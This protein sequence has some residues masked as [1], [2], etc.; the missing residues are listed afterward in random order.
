MSTKEVRPR[1]GSTTVPST[2]AYYKITANGIGDI[3]VNATG[4]NVITLGDGN[5]VNA[6]FNDLRMEL[7]ELKPPNRGERSPRRSEAR[8]GRLRNRIRTLS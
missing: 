7:D 3:N 4:A 1:G 6:A 5:I 8:D 2:T